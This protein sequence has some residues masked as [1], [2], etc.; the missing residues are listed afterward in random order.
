MERRYCLKSNSSR[1]AARI[2]CTQR[3]RGREK[4]DIAEISEILVISCRSPSPSPSPPPRGC[5]SLFWNRKIPG[6]PALLSKG[7]TRTARRILDIPSG[8]ERERERK[9]TH[10]RGNN[11]DFFVRCADLLWPSFNRRAHLWNRPIEML[12]SSELVVSSEILLTLEFQ[13]ASQRV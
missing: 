8:L 1:D 2:L 12:R 13:L 10:H 9:N 11:G 7:S 5:L 6:T 3:K 4:S